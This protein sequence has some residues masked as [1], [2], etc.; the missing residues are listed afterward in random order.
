MGGKVIYDVKIEGRRMVLR[1]KVREIGEKYGYVKVLIDSCGYL[2][3]SFDDMCCFE[4]VDGSVEGEI[5]ECIPDGRYRLID[6]GGM[7]KL[8]KIEDI[9]F[10]YL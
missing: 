5:F 8:Q 1:K 2:F 7:W 9:F 10:N 4:I 6:V 3:I